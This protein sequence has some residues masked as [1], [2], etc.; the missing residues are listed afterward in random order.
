MDEETQFWDSLETFVC[1][2]CNEKVWLRP[3]GADDTYYPYCCS[4]CAARAD[5]DSSEPDEV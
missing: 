2:W 3:L 1:L 5:V 4:L